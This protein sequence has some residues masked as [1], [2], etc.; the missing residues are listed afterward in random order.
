ML[1]LVVLLHR[2]G[3]RAQVAAAAALLPMTPLLRWQFGDFAET[4][5]LEDGSH[6]AATT[7]GWVTLRY[8]LFDGN[9]PLVPW[10]LFPL[11]GAL[12][13]RTEAL[14]MP[15]ARRLLLLALPLAIA[16]QVYAGWAEA[17]AD[18]LGGL[19]PHLLSEWTPTTIPFVLLGLCWSITA[20]AGFAWL[21]SADTLPRL[22]LPLQWLGRASLTHY[23][24]HLGTV[25]AALKLQYPDEDWPIGIGLAAFAIYV[26]AAVPLSWLWFRRFHRGP[27][28][29][30]WALASGRRG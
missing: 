28:E 13:L 18:A 30:L 14:A 12:L 9:Y 5:W 10:L 3:T 7:F 26:A 23:L 6:L 20:I 25:V 8:Y 2:A 21:A 17:N 16:M 4:D 22:L 29:A 11:L 24:L 19:S 27:C 15:R 1:P